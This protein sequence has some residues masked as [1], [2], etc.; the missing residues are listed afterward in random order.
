MKKS[1]LLIFGIIVCFASCKNFQYLVTEV[2]T[3]PITNCP[4]NSDCLLELIPNST[5]SFKN[6]EFWNTYPTIKEGN[7]T[8]LKYTFNKKTPKNTQDGQ[9]TEHVYAELEP[10]ITKTAL[11]NA[12]LKNIKLAYCKKDDSWHKVVE[13]VLTV[14]WYKDNDLLNLVKLENGYF[15]FLPNHKLKMNEERSFKK[16]NKI[17]NTFKV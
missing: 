14:D 15:A 16:Y 6:D 5:I 10:T 1:F 8:L 9:Y 3:S 7:K 2:K 12:A 17:R 13:Y 4:E 11:K